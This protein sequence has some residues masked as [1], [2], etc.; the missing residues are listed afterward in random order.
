[1]KIRGYVAAPGGAKPSA[2]VGEKLMEKTP[3]AFNLKQWPCGPADCGTTREMTP[4]LLPHWAYHRFPHSTK[5][6]K[7]RLAVA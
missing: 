2:P 6:R 4:S 5:L 3:V 1:M 7:H